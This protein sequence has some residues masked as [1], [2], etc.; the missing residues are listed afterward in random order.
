MASSSGE[1]L[2]Q[3]LYAEEIEGDIAGAITSYEKI[4]SDSSAPKNHR[5]QALYRQGM[6]YLKNKEKSQAATV[7]EKL[8][9]EYP[10]QSTLV[11]KAMP[12]LAG[13]QNFDPAALMPPE[14]LM[15]LELGS[16]GE[17]IE[18]LQGHPLRESV[19]DDTDECW[20]SKSPCWS[21]EPEH[22]RRIQED[23][24]L[25][26]RDHGVF[27]SRRP[28]KHG[29]CSASRGERCL[30]GYAPCGSGHGRDARRVY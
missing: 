6:C 19:G 14:T 29:F 20:G 24:E 21:L 11:E 12:I 15:Y 18:T 30:A 26:H 9:A 10:G 25:C 5:A 27:R 1:L 16:P 23:S 3:G 8:V 4:I 22:D 17:Q 2:Q 7:L 28:S 13:L